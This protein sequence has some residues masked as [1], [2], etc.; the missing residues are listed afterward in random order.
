MTYKRVVLIYVQW[1]IAALS[2]E[3]SQVRPIIQ[4]V[5]AGFAPHFVAARVLRRRLQ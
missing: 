3:Y 2:A 1:M 5:E 4:F